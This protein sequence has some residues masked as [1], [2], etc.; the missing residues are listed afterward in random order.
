VIEF[1]DRS[2]VV[3]VNETLKPPPGEGL[4]V[5]ARVSLKKC[6]ATDRATREYI[7]DTEHPRHKKQMRILQNKEN[8]KFI[9]FDID[10]ALRERYPR[11][12]SRNCHGP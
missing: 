12:K 9:S 1:D 11:K 8:T 6:W 7:K 2:C 10:T 5:P 3:Y 4:N